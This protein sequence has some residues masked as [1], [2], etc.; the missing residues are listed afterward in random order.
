MAKAEYAWLELKTLT[1]H[2]LCYI[3]FMTKIIQ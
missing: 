3:K 1:K 2:S